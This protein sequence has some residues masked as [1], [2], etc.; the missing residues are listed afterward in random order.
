[1]ED[2]RHHCPRPGRIQAYRSRGG[3]TTQAL[4][5]AAID[6]GTT[7]IVA[8][9]REPR[10]RQS[11]WHCLELQPADQCGEDILSRVNYA[12]K[13]GLARL[14][15]LAAE[16]INTA[17]T[18]ASNNAGIDRE[19]IYEVVVAGNTV[20]TH[21][22]MGIDPAYMI[23]E[24]YVPVVRRY[25]TLGSNAGGIGMTATRT[26]ASSSSPRS[27]TSSAGIS[28]QISLLPVWP[29]MMEISLLI[30]IGTNFEVVL[31]NKKTGCSPVPVLPVL[32]WK[33]GRYSSGCGPTPGQSRR[34]HIDLHTLEPSYQT[35]NRVKPGGSVDQD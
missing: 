14:Q 13:G 16:S 9:L 18:Q 8:Y 12:R 7:T 27:A 17:I 1:M 35:I 5:G 6:L 22:L 31:G 15:E 2:H 32:P 30:D 3:D 4:Y 21:I 25:L 26:P 23:A 33:A 28:W 19:H 34:S 11:P 20:M 29:N 10:G 24:P